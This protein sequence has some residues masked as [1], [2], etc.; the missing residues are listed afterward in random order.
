[1]EFLDAKE[2]GKLLDVSGASLS[3]QLEALEPFIV[4]V[5]ELLTG[6]IISYR[7]A[8]EDLLLSSHPYLLTDFPV[9]N[10]M[11]EGS[12]V[13]HDRRTGRIYPNLIPNSYSVTY[14]VGYRRRSLPAIVSQLLRDLTVYRLTGQEEFK[15]QATANVEV[16]RINRSNLEQ[17]RNGQ[18]G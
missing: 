1:M 3:E 9:Q 16:L 18:A 7:I 10:V 4:R 2:I 11:I 14:E 8:S 17:Q 13:D 15:A 12:E 5:A 6:S